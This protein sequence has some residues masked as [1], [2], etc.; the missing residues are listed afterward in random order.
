MLG[1]PVSLDCGADGQPQ[2]E[3]TWHRERR[4]V[5]EGAH[6]HVFSNGTL[7]ITSTQRS[8]AGL[9]TCTAKNLAGRASQDL[10]LVIH[11]E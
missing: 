1:Q 7:T 9:Y 10:R 4:P 2:P 6:V 3:V 8:D 5:A 11:S